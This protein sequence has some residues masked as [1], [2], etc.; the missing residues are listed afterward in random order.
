MT[1]APTR[2]PT[3]GATAPRALTF[4]A[5]EYLHFLE[6]CDW[7]EDQKREF[8]EAL[9]EIILGFVDLGFG[10][11]PLQMAHAS[12]ST[13]E[14]DSPSMLALQHHSEIEKQFEKAASGEE[15]N[16]EDS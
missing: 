16:A 12:S 2:P 15:R 5:Q 3:Q 8:V 1:D 11:S 9:W 7:T 10:I 14:V 13:L 6:D 4:D